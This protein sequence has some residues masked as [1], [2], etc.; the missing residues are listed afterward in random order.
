MITAAFKTQ[1]DFLAHPWTPF[2]PSD[3]ARV[4]RGIERSVPRWF[5][6]S[7]I[8]TAGAVA[9][10]LAIASLAAWG[11]RAGASAAGTLLLGCSS[12]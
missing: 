4:R 9:A 7:A 1:G 11:F 2:A 10:T 5:L 3:A 6:N 8:L 12:R